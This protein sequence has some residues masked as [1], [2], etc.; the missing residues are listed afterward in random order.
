[1]VAFYNQADQDIYNSGSK[2]V[3]QERY[4]L[5]YTAPATG[6]PTPASG[7]ITNTNA[8][9]NSGND[10][11]VYNPDPN[12]I[13]NRDYDPYRYRNAAENSYLPGRSNATDPKYLNQSYDPSGKI[14][15]A[16]T[17]YNKA[18]ADAYRYSNPANQLAMTETFTGMRP[19]KS[20]MDYYGGQ[21]MDNREQYGA[22]G[23]YETVD[24]PFAYSS[25]T[26]LNKFKDNYPGF[27]NK[28]EATGA[29]KAMGA[30]SNLIPG[31]GI[32]EFLAS[33]APP[34]RRSMME[35]ELSGKGIMVNNTGQIVQGGGA[36]DTSG[37]VMAGYN[38]PKM[39]A[40]TFDKRIANIQKTLDKKYGSKNYKG[41][42]T[43]LDERVEAIKKAKA[44]F[45]GAQGRTDLI[46]ED[47][48]VEKNKKKSNNFL[49]KIF[50]RNKT[51]QP[52]ADA[53]DAAAPTGGGSYNASGG[54]RDSNYDQEANIRGGGGGNTAT[55][56][57][58]QT[59]REAT[60]DGNPN[61]GTAQGYSQHYARGGRAGYFFGGRVNFKN[62]GLAS[63]L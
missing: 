27:Y 52:A 1:M 60:Y 39:T 8:F 51:T 32:A 41:D 25:E 40:E 29:E 61:T 12:S 23:Q 10:F 22:Q 18:S 26:E 42:K 56:A 31:K 38:A 24:S 44:D 37:N 55:N 9:T 33:Y 16:Q 43:K 20:V 13:V 3:P 36:Y 11:S 35:N 19:S 50:R 59:A 63:I 53:A 17:M 46:F 34:N 62:G 47:E 45:L 15:N 14:A 2:F 48:E 28:P 6:A 57:Q 49:A 54:V 58:G 5:G 21:I 30:L 7:G 4:R